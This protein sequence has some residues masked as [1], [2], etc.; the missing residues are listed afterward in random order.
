M[1]RRVVVVP[2][3]L[4]L[5]LATVAAGSASAAASSKLS[6]PKR[7]ATEQ[8]IHETDQGGWVAFKEAVK[9]AKTCIWSSSPTIAGFDEKLACGTGEE[10]RGAKFPVNTSTSGKSWK[11]SLI[12]DG[13]GAIGYYWQ[14]IEAGRIVVATHHLNANG[15]GLVFTR[16]GVAS[17]TSC[18]WSSYPT[19]AGFDTSLGCSGTVTRSAQ[20]GFNTSTSARSW[21]VWVVATKGLTSWG[22]YWIVDQAG[23]G[24]GAYFACTGDAPGAD[25]IYGSDSSNYSPAGVPFTAALP[26]DNNALYYAVTAQLGGSGNVSCTTTVEWT[27]GGMLHSTT[28][29]GSASGSYNIANAE[30]CNGTSFGDGWQAC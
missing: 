5:L 22:Y 17:G 26:L 6:V 10:A 30:V 23:N 24:P 8:T 13:T 16:D 1:I 20:F 3:T 18:A 28:Q 14:V 9:N 21:L 2:A 11:I 12:V 19:V 15:G 25:V 29:H 27:S 4:L 7:A